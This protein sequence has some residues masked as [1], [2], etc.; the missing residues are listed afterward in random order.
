MARRW[1]P[2]RAQAL[3]GL[4]AAQAQL[5]LVLDQVE[6]EAADVEAAQ[7]AVNA[8]AAAYTRALEGATEEDRRA[9]LAQLKQAEAAVTVAQAGYNRVKGNPLIAALPESLQLQQATLAVEA[10]QAQYDKVL[11][12]STADVTSGAYA[13]LANA[14]AQL[15]R[16]ERGPED[17]QIRALE[18]QVQQAET[19]LYLS[20]LQLDKT[21]I[22][23]PVDGVVSSLNVA[24]GA[25]VAPGA[26]VIELLSPENEI[27]VAVEESRLRDVALGLPVT[28]RVDAYPGR[29][30]DGQVIRVAPE[31][32]AATRTVDVTIQPVD[33]ESLLAPGMFATVEIG[34]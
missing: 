13:Q 6:P 11:K 26:P 34:Q 16:L 8:A 9:A 20:Q 29:T 2:S 32:N 4:E 27:V 24:E 21:R 22:A 7:A 14:R 25:M 5:D 10:A 12:G 1:K 31:L 33:E 18:A 15:E 3:A 19:A 17:A 23:A 28:I 30:F